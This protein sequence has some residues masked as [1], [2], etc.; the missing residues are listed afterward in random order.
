MG[1]NTR[2][3]VYFI[4]IFLSLG[5]NIHKE[6]PHHIFMHTFKHAKQSRT[7]AHSLHAIRSML[8]MFLHRVRGLSVNANDV[9]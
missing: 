1:I 7:H 5:Q 3:C 2:Q 8:E 9:C 4:Y 6:T